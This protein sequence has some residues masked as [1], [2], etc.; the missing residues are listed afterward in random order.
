MFL[1]LSSILFLQLAV[2]LDTVKFALP[3]SRTAA[4]PMQTAYSPQVKN[5][6]DSFVECPASTERGSAHE[7]RPEVS[8]EGSTF[9]GV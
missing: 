4:C 9:G 5:S 7:F 6:I 3:R 1:Q 8:G 2:N